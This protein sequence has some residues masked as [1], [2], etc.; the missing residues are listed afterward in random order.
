MT[1]IF[2]EEKQ[3]QKLNLMRLEEEERLMKMLST[4]YDIK[5]IDLSSVS[6]NTDALR[7]IDQDIA[8]K[9]E[10]V[11]FDI[12][13]KKIS[14][15]L[16]NPNNETTEETVDVLKRKGYEVQ[17]YLT[18]KTSLKKAWAL[19]K[20]LSFAVET[21][22][23]SLDISDSEIEELVDKTKN[24]SDIKS[25]IQ[26]ALEEKKSHRLS[27]LLAVIMAGGLATKASDI[28]IESEEGFSRL[29]YRLDGI[30]IEVIQFDLETY[31]S[32]LSRLK[33]LSGLKLNI[34]ENSQDG[35][36]TIKIYT[37]DIEIRTSTIP[38]AYGE[39]I[40]MRILNPKSIAGTIEDLGMPE[41]LYSIVQK[42]IARPNGMILVTGPTGSGKTT[43][44]YAFLRKTM[45]PEYKIITIEDPIEY[46]LPG[47]VQTQVEEKKGYTFEAGL[48]SV[49]RQDPDIIMVG[50]IRDTETAITAIQAALTGHL[51]FSTLHTNNAAGTFTRLIDL[52]AD[53]KVLTSAVHLALAQRLVRKLC[54]DCRAKKPISEKEKDVIQA[55]LTSLVGYDEEKLFTTI[56][57]EL[58]QAVGCDKCNKTGYQGRIGVYEGILADA[59]I[60][61]VVRM[62]PSE[63]DIKEAAKNQKIMDMKQD[64]VLKI[65]NGIT[66][67]DELERVVDL[68]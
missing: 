61:E 16:N 14:I 45:S 58:Y 53:S 48:R 40:V 28:H 65:L 51:V 8:E 64:G 55:T 20:D 27:K 62:S 57:S 63:R 17:L 59:A 35:R 52:G 54:P 43:T 9:S 56:P 5:Y 24:L 49:V 3:K 29:R 68:Y 46:H 30:L 10:C 34:K 23:G 39:S 47:I 2:D 4:K 66:T 41:K 33:L 7:L 15:A 1:L 32:L 36:F 19:Y 67:M 38:G 50:E 13:G 12:V 42:E 11:V 37:N 44:L 31:H 25:L 6:I 21:E 60:E 18:S 22:A 26:N